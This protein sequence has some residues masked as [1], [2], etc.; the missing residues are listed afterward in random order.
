MVEVGDVGKYVWGYVQSFNNKGRIVQPTR[1]RTFPFTED[2]G[3]VVGISSL[4][5]EALSARK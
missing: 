1:G 5:R 4:N 3:S 2:N